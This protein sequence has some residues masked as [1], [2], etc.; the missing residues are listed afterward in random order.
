MSDI[1]RL[2]QL[3]IEYILPEKVSEKF[4]GDFK[5]SF[6][7]IVEVN[8]FTSGSTSKPKLIKKNTSVLFAEGVSVFKE[9]SS[10]I[11]DNSVIHTTSISTHM[12]V[13]TFYIIDVQ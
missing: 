2:N 4:S 11:K 13:L 1:K 3:N 6:P 12:F 7:E 8:F 9:F 5:F 10:F